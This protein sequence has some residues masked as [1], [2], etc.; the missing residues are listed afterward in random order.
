MVVRI[1]D[2]NITRRN[3]TKFYIMYGV[4]VHRLKRISIMCILNFCASTI[5]IKPSFNSKLHL[6]DRKVVDCF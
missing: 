6:S 5:A 1:I 4:G 2:V 3:S